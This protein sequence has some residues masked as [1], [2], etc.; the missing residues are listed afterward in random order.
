MVDPSDYIPHE[1]LST[2]KAAKE[3]IARETSAI[4]ATNYKEEEPLLYHAY[5]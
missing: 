1:E 5:P 2:T 4:K 3:T